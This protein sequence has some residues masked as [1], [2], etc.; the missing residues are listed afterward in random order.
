MQHIIWDYNGTL[1]NDADLCVSV[2][3]KMLYTR[4]L[5]TITSK[6]Y[7]K[8]FD[9]PVKDYYQ[10]IGFD[11][12]KESFEKVGTEFIEKYNLRINES[13]L[14]EGTLEILDY[15]KKKGIKQ[16]ILSARKQEHLYEELEIFGIKKYFTHIKGLTDHYAHGKL[17]KA[18]ELIKEINIDRQKIVLIGD[19]LHDKEVADC[20]G[21]KCFLLT[22]GHHSQARLKQDTQLIFNSFNEILKFIEK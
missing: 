3:N 11:F 14:H 7:R 8:I 16:S 2:I 21:I 15:F 10:K 20:V 5:K 18:K 22:H 12:E 6:K 1:L 17:E 13:R 4:K 9:F 19:T